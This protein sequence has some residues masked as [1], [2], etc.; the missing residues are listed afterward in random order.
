M[1]GWQVYMGEYLK[2]IQEKFE[3]EKSLPRNA[4][5]APIAL[6]MEIAKRMYEQASEEE[7]KKLEDI[8]EQD[9]QTRSEHR[10]H[11]EEADVSDPVLQTKSVDKICMVY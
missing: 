8:I 5:M 2:E 10:A 1:A 9:V 3:E 11:L 4:A 7:K 6:R